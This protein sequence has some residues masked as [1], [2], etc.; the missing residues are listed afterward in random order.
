MGKPVRVWVEPPLPD[1]A[2]AGMTPPADAPA[3][4]FRLADGKLTFVA[5]R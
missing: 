2:L 4:E 5:A 1:A 3:A